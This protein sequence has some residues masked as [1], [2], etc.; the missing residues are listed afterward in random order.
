MN[1]FNNIQLNIKETS[2][3]L[4][5]SKSYIAVSE[6]EITLEKKKVFLSLSQPLHPV[7]SVTDF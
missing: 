4:S 5:F 7:A 3:M 1:T 2:F 6:R